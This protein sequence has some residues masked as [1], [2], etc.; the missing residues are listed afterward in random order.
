ME[1]VMPVTLKQ[2]IKE[3]TQTQ[4]T[5][6]SD[7]AEQIDQLGAIT[8]QADATAKKIRELTNDLNVYKQAVKDLAEQVTK[9]YDEA[10][11]DPDSKGEEL[12]AEFA[13]EV[14]PKGNSRVIKDVKLVLKEMG[15][16]TFFKVASVALKDIDAY[17]TPEQINKVLKNVRTNRGIKIIRRK[18]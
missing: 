17:L 12:G 7:F 3:A 2:K 13:L 16:D 14:G 6:L 10:Q 11:A 5:G 4:P 8:A 9:A 15:P 18:K 1:G